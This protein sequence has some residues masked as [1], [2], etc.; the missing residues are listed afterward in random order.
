MIDVQ[1]MSVLSYQW[2]SQIAICGKPT[3]YNFDRSYSK[4]DR[5]RLIGQINL[6]NTWLGNAKQIFF[7]LRYLFQLSKIE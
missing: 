7:L 6:G 1:C 4:W 2:Q 5:K 3:P